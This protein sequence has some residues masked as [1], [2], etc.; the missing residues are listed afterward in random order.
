MKGEIKMDATAK[1]HPKCYLD[2]TD[3]NHDLAAVVFKGDEDTLDVIAQEMNEL[4]DWFDEDTTEDEKKRGT[5]Y[6][7]ADMPASSVLE[8]MSRHPEVKVAAFIL[9]WGYPDMVYVVYSEAGSSTFDYAYP[10][11]H[12]DGHNEPSFRWYGECRITDSDYTGEEHWSSVGETETVH[13]SFPFADLW[14]S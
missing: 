13:Y 10:L 3:E 6:F 4:D 7:V 12:F 14:N 11:A 1:N 9:E 8:I 5:R 2:L